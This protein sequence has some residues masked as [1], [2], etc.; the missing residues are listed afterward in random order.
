MTDGDT[1]VVDPGMRVRLIGVDTPESVD[2]RRGVQCFGREAA[3]Y[4][5]QLVRPGTPVRLVYDV[6]RRDRYGRTL[7]YVY[8]L[9]DGLFVNAALLRDGYAQVATFPPNVAHVEEFGRLQR[10]ARAAGQGLWSACRR[11]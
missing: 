10:Q 2:P 7:A 6:E 4:T 8:R 5:A 1:V 3:D 11:K 9:S